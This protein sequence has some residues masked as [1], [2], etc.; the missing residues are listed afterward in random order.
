METGLKHVSTVTVSAANTALTMGSGDME[1][2][3]TP[4]N[5]FGR[6]GSFRYTCNGSPNGKCRNES[7]CAS[8]ARRINYC[9]SNDGNIS[10]QAI[11]F[12]RNS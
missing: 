4:H 8:S 12:G 11:S 2:F 9:R 5:G 6:Y 3:A 1:V 7:S 10:Y